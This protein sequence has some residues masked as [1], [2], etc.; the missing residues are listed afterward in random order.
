M[1]GAMGDDVGRNAWLV[2]IRALGM[3]LLVDE[4]E[5]EDDH[6]MDVTVVEI[7]YE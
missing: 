5:T 7:D 1:V 6:G 2:N 3:G 4:A